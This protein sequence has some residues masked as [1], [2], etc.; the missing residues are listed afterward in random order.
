MYA[1]LSRLLA[2]A[3]RR[4]RYRVNALAGSGRHAAADDVEG[5]PLLA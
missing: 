2:G 3:V 4:D 5:L 1:R